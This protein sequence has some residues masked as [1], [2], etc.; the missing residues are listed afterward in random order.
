MS[1]GTTFLSRV[2]HEET[3]IDDLSAVKK[4]IADVKKSAGG[5]M[6]NITDVIIDIG[7]LFGI[8]ARVL[9]AN[10]SE[11]KS[12]IRS[13]A[14]R[15]K[16]AP[17]E[18]TNLSTLHQA[19]LAANTAEQAKKPVGESVEDSSFHGKVVSVL[20]SL[21]Y[22]D[23]VLNDEAAKSKITAAVADMSDAGA[24]KRVINRMASFVTNE[25]IEAGNAISTN[26]FVNDAVKIIRALGL[27]VSDANIV[28]T[29]KGMAI[30]RAILTAM[31]MNPTLKPAMR[32]FL[33][34]MK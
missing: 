29:G 17:T 9:K 22:S 26:E 6:F 27:D 8:P 10:V 30:Q 21:G 3:G 28:K 15:I 12:S 33:S 25:G 14:D 20:K 4:R 18:S 11:L 13:A 2:L 1:I 32:A 34:K 19:L 23:A 7:S 5:E 24:V 16:L 31:R